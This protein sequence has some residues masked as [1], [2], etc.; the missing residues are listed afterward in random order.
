[1]LVVR[2]CVRVCV[3]APVCACPCSLMVGL[4]LCIH[5]EGRG[6]GGP[7]HLL[8]EHLLRHGPLLSQR[9]RKAAALGHRVVLTPLETAQPVCVARGV[10][11]KVCEMGM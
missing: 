11:R 2:A 7:T 4:C 10:C 3:C 5:Q 9:Q 1:M 6:M 8:P